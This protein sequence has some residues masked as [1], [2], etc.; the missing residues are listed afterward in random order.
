MDGHSSSTRTAGDHRA[1][2]LLTPVLNRKSELGWAGG[3]T[4]RSVSGAGF[5]C[6]GLG[7]LVLVQGDFLAGEAFEFADQLPFAAFG[8]ELVV[9]VDAE[10]G[11]VGVGVG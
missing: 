7:S 4:R 11:E 3:S 1:L 6:G 5:G 8:G 2:A 9:V 10:V